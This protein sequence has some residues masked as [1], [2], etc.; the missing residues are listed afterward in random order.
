MGGQINLHTSE[1]GGRWPSSTWD[2]VAAGVGTRC[3]GKCTRTWI[4]ETP[5]VREA[6]DDKQWQKKMREGHMLERFGEPEEVVGA[7][8]YLAAE[9]SSFVTGTILSVDGGWTAQ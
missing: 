8:I 9:A 3:P 6:M 2:Q 1:Q 4:H 7:A 5:L